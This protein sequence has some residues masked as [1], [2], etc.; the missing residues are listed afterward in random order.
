MFNDCRP[1]LRQIP[2][3]E[4]V[5]REIHFMIV[6]NLYITELLLLTKCSHDQKK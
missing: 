1:A 6:L 4:L 5:L 2:L 3:K